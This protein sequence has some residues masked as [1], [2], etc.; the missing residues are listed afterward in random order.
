MCSTMGGLNPV[1]SNFSS[2]S[3]IAETTNGEVPNHSNPQL[4][5]GKIAHNINP[6]FLLY[7][8]PVEYAPR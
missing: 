6:P 2:T 7:S 1:L 8:R 5:P 4:A 3:G